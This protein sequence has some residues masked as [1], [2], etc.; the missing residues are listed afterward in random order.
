MA[1]YNFIDNVIS[2]A[3]ENCVVE[4]LRSVF[5]AEEVSMMDD[6]R[7]ELIGSEPP[8]VVQERERDLKRLDV[9]QE[10]FQVCNRY[11]NA[12]YGKSF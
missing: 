2:L 11:S 6:E 4:P 12:S 5:E 3:I 7:L 1:L 8:K 10:V 9:L